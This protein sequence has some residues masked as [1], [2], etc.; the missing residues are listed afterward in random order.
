MATELELVVAT[1]DTLGGV[2]G[3]ITMELAT[4]IPGPAGATGATGATGAAGPNT[5]S[6]S[7]TTAFN[8][9]IGGNGS[10]AYSVTVGSGLSLSGGTLTA[11]G[12]GGTWGSITGTLSSQ[13]DLQAALNARAVLASA[14]TFTVG[15]QVIQTGAA[16]TVGLS[17]RG[18]ASQSA[19]WL[20]FRNSGGSVVGGV[21]P[22]GFGGVHLDLN[23]VFNA[24]VVRAAGT[25]ILR[26]LSAA[27]WADSATAAFFQVG[28]FGGAGAFATASAGTFSRF[29]IF[30]NTTGFTDGSYLSAPVPTALI[31]GDLTSASRVGLLLRAASGQTGD[32][33]QLQSSASSTLTAFR[34][35]GGWQPASMSDA[36]A[37]NNTVYFSTTASRLVYKDSGGTVNNLY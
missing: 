22:S 9:L 26:M 24:A 19:A 4:G 36:S 5:I 10:T 37:P 3:A 2:A 17:L 14:N 25:Q 8:S 18:A 21:V 29:G 12:G 27:S 28:T 31:Q 23:D 35:G 1:D 15:G 11:T 13:T 16:G 30:S 6:T 7:T 32:L 34:A 20:E 33:L